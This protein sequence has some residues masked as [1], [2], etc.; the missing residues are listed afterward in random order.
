MCTC[1]H[2]YRH[3]FP[4]IQNRE[5]LTFPGMDSEEARNDGRRHIKPPTLG[6]LSA[7]FF[8]RFIHRR[9]RFNG[10]VQIVG[11]PFCHKNCSISTR[12]PN[13][14]QHTIN[15]QLIEDILNLYPWQS[16]GS[17]CFLDMI[18]ARNLVPK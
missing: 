9:G 11:S 14:S 1:R 15:H 4:G 18:W 7:V 17:T 5:V 10:G 8:H 3:P 2:I 16:L 6:Q 13:R 12:L